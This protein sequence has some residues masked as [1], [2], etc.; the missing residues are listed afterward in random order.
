[1]FKKV[2]LAL[3]ILFLSYTLVYAIT[4]VR[5]V[6]DNEN[7][8]SPMLFSGGTVGLEAGT[9][10]IGDVDIV[11]FPAGMV[12]TAHNA[13]TAT[14]TSAEID[15]QGFNALRVYY[16]ETVDGGT[17]S[18]N[19]THSDTSGG[20]FLAS[21]S[22]IENSSVTDITADVFYVV[23]DIGKYIKVVATETV[24]TGTITVKVQPIVR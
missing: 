24:D 1:M 9:K 10:N 3:G 15:C 13:I 8:V 21:H 16:D 20:T 6:D 12:T 18:I 22:T 5:I 7:P 17:W 23:E 2:L 4:P 14:A 11:S 19:I